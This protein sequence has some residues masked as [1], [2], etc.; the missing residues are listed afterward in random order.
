MLA[1][2]VVFLLAL[3]FVLST[4]LRERDERDDNDDND[5]VL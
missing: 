4:Y 3:G 5:E 2:T 1:S